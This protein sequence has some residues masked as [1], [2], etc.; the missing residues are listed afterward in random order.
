MIVTLNS[1]NALRV[2]P[3]EKKEGEG[4]KE[5]GREKK[6]GARERREERERTITVNLC[7]FYFQT[8]KSYQE[9]QNRSRSYDT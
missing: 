9:S 5:R 8:Y 7:V 6:E 1:S 4:E 2:S 3:K